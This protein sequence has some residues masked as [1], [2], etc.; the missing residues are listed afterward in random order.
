[1]PIVVLSNLIS[2]ILGNKDYQEFGRSAFGSFAVLAAFN[3]VSLGLVILSMINFFS[4]GK[5][6]RRPFRAGKPE[7]FVSVLLLGPLL[8]FLLT[9]HN[10]ASRYALV[11]YP[12]LFLLPAHYLMENP[13]QRRWLRTAQAAMV[14]TM[15]FNGIL[16][17]AFFRYQGQRIAHADYFIASFH[18][19]EQARQALRADAGPACRIHLDRDP[20]NGEVSNP[21]M[22]NPETRG[23]VGLSRYVNINEPFD[24]SAKNAACEKVYRILPPGKSPATNDRV[25]YHDNGLI[26]IDAEA[27]TTATRPTRPPVAADRL[28]VT[29]KLLWCGLPLATGAREARRILNDIGTAP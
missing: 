22:R 18:K 1:V 24:P 11:L 12:L 20:I 23:L 4:A 16:M 9:A 14:A 19:M 2:S 21:E 25:V 3:M 5:R 29:H 8:I 10:F 6:L 26:I 17:I 28:T 13:A 7:I 27:S 15:V